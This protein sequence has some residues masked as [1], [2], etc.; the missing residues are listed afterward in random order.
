MKI[1]ARQ[2][3]YKIIKH[4]TYNKFFQP[5][6]QTCNKLEWLFSFAEVRENKTHF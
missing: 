5:F 6:F 4:L 2:A 3:S 1:L